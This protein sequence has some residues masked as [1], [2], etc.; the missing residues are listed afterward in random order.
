MRR[1]LTIVELMVVLAI[2]AIVTAVT[3]P[4]LA[5]FLDWIAVDTAAQEVSTAI[6]VARSAAVMQATRSRAVIAAESLRIDRWRQDS[7]GNLHRWP[8]PDRHGVALDVS[9]PVVMFDPIGL[10]WGP[11]NTKVVL[12]R[13]TRV[14]TL[15]V[16]R[17]GRVKRW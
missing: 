12:R 9:N 13:G 5:G 8:G 3:L 2:L 15:T 16:S 1:G 14:A 6:A 10:A 7:W 11:S 17:L 4:R